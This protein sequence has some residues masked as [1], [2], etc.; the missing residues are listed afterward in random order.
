[1]IT[2]DP[3]KAFPTQ[4]Y[5]LVKNYRVAHLLRP[6]F[7]KKYINLR[8]GRETFRFYPGVDI[9]KRQHDAERGVDQY[10]ADWDDADDDY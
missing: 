4:M 10:N 6:I 1:M 8:K 7:N 5:L 9:S 3:S 2:V